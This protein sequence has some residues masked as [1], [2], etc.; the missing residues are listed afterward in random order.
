[1]NNKVSFILYTLFF[2]IS[3][4]C[5][6]FVQYINTNIITASYENSFLIFFLVNSLFLIPSNYF[7]IK[8]SNKEHKKNH[9]ILSAILFLLLNISFLL[10]NFYTNTFYLLVSAVIIVILNISSLYNL[11]I[12]YKNDKFYNIY[13][14]TIKIFLLFAFIFNL[15][16]NSII[17]LDILSSVK[18][19]EIMQPVIISVF[20]YLIGIFLYFQ[21]KKNINDIEL[22]YKD[23]RYFLI[24]I[25]YLFTLLIY[26]FIFVFF[27]TLK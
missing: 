14:N 20:N 15:I 16:F 26:P 13:L 22:D 10:Y 2:L 17:L 21:S 12:I 18:N 1:M 25:S 23:F 6:G 19:S 11:N 24:Y 5:I 4:S 7:L 9:I 3:A 8:S 27:I